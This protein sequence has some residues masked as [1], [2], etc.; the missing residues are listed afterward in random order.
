MLCYKLKDFSLFFGLLV[1]WY[2]MNLSM[3]FYKGWRMNGGPVGND[4]NMVAVIYRKMTKTNGWTHIRDNNLLGKRH[5]GMAWHRWTLK[6]QNVRWCWTFKWNS[7]WG[8]TWPKAIKYIPTSNGF[9]QTE[10]ELDIKHQ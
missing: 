7:G 4:I 8:W 5:W 9:F 1:I 6:W 10:A 2:E 3:I